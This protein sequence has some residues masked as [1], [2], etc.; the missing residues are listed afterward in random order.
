MNST[1]AK[2]IKLKRGVSPA[3]SHVS[4]K[5]ERSMDPPGNFMGGATAH[6]TSIKLKRGVSPAPSHVSMK[7]ERS[8][9]PPGNFLGGTRQDSIKLKRGVSPAPSH[10]SMKSDRSMDPPG[11]LMGETTDQRLR[12]GREDMTSD[13][14]RTLL[15]EDHF[16]CSVCTEVLKDPISI[17]CGHS[18]CRQCI[19]S[20]W[21]QRN[22]AGH[23]AC[24]QCSH[25]YSSCPAL[26]TN[27]ALATVVQQ[28]Q[29]I[30][31]VPPAHCYAGPGDV[32]CDFCTGRKLR[33]VKSCLTCSASYCESHIRQHYTVL[34][35]EKHTLVEPEHQ[36]ERP[37]EQWN[38]KTEDSKLPEDKMICPQHNKQKEYFCKT[39]NIFI[40]SLCTTEGHRGHDIKTEDMSQANIDIFENQKID[41]FDDDK[42]VNNHKRKIETTTLEEICPNKEEKWKKLLTEV[43]AT[44][45]KLTEE[46]TGLKTENS[47]LMAKNATLEAGES[48]L[49][50]MCAKLETKN[51]NL[52][53]K[54][55][56]LEAGESELRGMCAELETTNSN[57]M[58]KNATL[59]AG[60]SRMTA[61]LE[62][63]KSEQKEKLSELKT[64]NSRLQEE[65]NKKETEN[66]ELTEENSEL[67]RK[68]SRLTKNNIKLEKKYLKLREENRELKREHAHL[69]ENASKLA[70]QNAELQEK[71]TKLKAKNLQLQEDTDDKNE[72]IDWLTEKNNKLQSDLSAINITCT[73]LKKNILGPF[74]GSALPANVI[75]DPDTAHSQLILSTDGKSLTLGKSVSL[76]IP[77]NRERFDY[78]FFVL[79]K[80]GF[81][82]GR[83]FWQVVVNSSC[84]IGVTKDSAQ[85]KG[86]F[87]FRP[88]LGYWLLRCKQLESQFFAWTY[89]LTACSVHSGLLNVCLDVE[90]RWVAFFHANWEHIYTFRK[91]GF[92]KGEKIYP[93]FYNMDMN[94]GLFIKSVP[95]I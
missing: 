18:Y 2:R 49:R 3:P 58:A 59:E 8:M 22:H 12:P 92:N 25:T 38:I 24:L 66:S 57:L 76:N 95:Y 86:N 28:L 23:Y 13:L 39:D 40:C 81:S 29:H 93:V 64:K 48:E 17:P 83:H 36:R 42:K 68:K 54:N 91:M 65:F 73:M 53:A 33:A 16:R 37:N 32:A 72:D 1:V 52:M 94:E 51:S 67:Y 44:T 82:S 41:M 69:N 87:P 80:E 45:F 62:T 26:Y 70:N 71:T 78:W 46:I 19:T 21:A 10:V 47:N 30:S 50:G 88:E 4:M 20:Y 34:V 11:N 84:I 75:L 63:K 27:S 15:T 77:D 79:G 43:K 55:A 56:T 9:D 14:S 85:R 89:P 6:M 31:P 7:S 74:K 5:S 60:E 90:E 35:L 61:E